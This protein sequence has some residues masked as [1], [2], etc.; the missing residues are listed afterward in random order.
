M[1]HD[2]HD[3]S[4]GFTSGI[5][6]GAVIGGALAL[7]FAPKAGTQLREEL[8]ESWGRCATRWPG[9][10]GSWRIVRASK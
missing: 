7:L 8:G 9:G 3:P 4:Y 6:T 10:T 1:L 2:R 5:L